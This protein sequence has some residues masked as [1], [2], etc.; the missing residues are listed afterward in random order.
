MNKVDPYFF[1]RLNNSA[2][3]LEDRKEE[4]RAPHL[5]FNEVG[6]TDKEYYKK[7]PTIYHLRKALISEDRKFDLREIYI[8]LAHMIK[9]RGNFLLEG[10]IISTES[11]IKSL[12]EHFNAIDEHIEDMNNG[13]DTDIPQEMF[14]CTEEQAVKAMEYFKK[15]AKKGSLWP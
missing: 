10:D 4:L 2:I 12:L 7:Y 9:Y 15:E 6:Y 1:D 8:A 11:N 3:H 13:L 14:H 5:L